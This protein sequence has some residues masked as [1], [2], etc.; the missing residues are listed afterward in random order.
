MGARSRDIFLSADPK[1]FSP[2]SIDILRVAEDCAEDPWVVGVDGSSEKA[3]TYGEW[4]STMFTISF[5]KS[6][7]TVGWFFSFLSEPYSSFLSEG[8]LRQGSLAGARRRCSRDSLDAFLAT[9]RAGEP[10][11]LKQNFLLDESKVLIW[12][13]LT[14]SWLLFF[15]G[16]SYMLILLVA[17]IWLVR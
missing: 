8:I 6:V 3:A 9:I 12:S 13:G 5:E 15:F 17:N 10:L 7:H 14:G 4:S 2:A 1:S 11:S 16:D